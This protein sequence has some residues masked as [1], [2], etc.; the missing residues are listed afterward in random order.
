MTR[1]R[2]NRK[3]TFFWQAVLIIL[4]VTVLA[5]V[6]FFSLRQDKLLAEE[7]A[8]QQAQAIAWPLARE[9]GTRLKIA[10]DDFAQAS[11][12]QEMAVGMIAGTVEPGPQQDARE[13]IGN[14]QAT[15]A[16]W[17]QEHPK[18]Q[19]SQLPQ[20]RCY[21]REGVLFYPRD[22]SEVPEPPDWFV[23]LPSDEAERWNAAETAWGRHDVAAARLALEAIARARGRSDD[24][25]RANAE[26]KLLLIEA[27]APNSPDRFRAFRELALKYPRI[28]TEAG[29]PL[30][31][32]AGHHALRLAPSGT[33]FDEFLDGFVFHVQNAPSIL[34]GKLL[35]EVESRAKAE[36][37]RAQ[38]RVRAIKSVWAAQEQARKLL[39]PVAR[40]KLTR[41]GV[42]ELSSE[43]GRFLAFC[44]PSVSIATNITL[45]ATNVSTTV[46]G[47]IL[48]VPVS[49]VDQAFQRAM[50]AGKVRPPDYAAVHLGFGAQQFDYF[51]ASL[52]KTGVTNHSAQP[53][54]T[55]VD[56]VSPGWAGGYFP[57]TLQLDLVDPELLFARHRQRVGLFGAVIIL[58]A[59]TA[60]VGLLASW[61]S[62]DR[63]QR[64]AEMKTNFVS[65]VSH[66]LRAPIAS[67]RLMAESLDRGKIPDPKK[68]TEYFRLIVQECRRLTSLIENVLDFSRMDQGRKQYE[69]EPTDLVALVRETVCLM[70]PYAAERQV[71]L[72]IA[73][74]A[75]P[76]TT[77][78][79]QPALDSR[80][81]QQ[82]LVNLLDNAIKHSPPG[83]TVL[84]GCEP[85]LNSQPSTVNLFVQD[86]GDGIPL[87]QH[88]KIFEPFYR[89]GSELRRETQGIGI[90]LTIV[91]H[92]V[93]AHSGRVGVQSEVG[94][95][96]RFTIELPV[97][98][99][100]NPN[101]Q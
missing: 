33:G 66:E 79:L 12:R 19:L 18:V 53:L 80:A 14:G 78:N 69:F 2:A 101:F 38:E 97:E 96:S 11:Q 93:K 81:I 84:V 17:Q 26:L 15:V 59:S 71:T 13:E 27:D 91:K 30:S 64:L 56:G 47:N 63:Q 55:V 28:Q 43:S 98:Q 25:V 74:D 61:R 73:P 70:E 34:T 76:I 29:L 16:R 23:S 5:G 50:R 87:A 6:G 51:H 24:P 41:L 86:H 77:N 44:S 72:E 36:D 99:I 83:T 49:V 39:R 3:S 7:E 85:S 42:V 10:I 20:T 37:G 75:P 52:M 90:G 82:A 45:A 46:S 8:R 31:D 40:D 94:K 48:L 88:E 4:P 67:V 35:D 60:L 95:G 58:A 100:P 68:Q 9:C 92:V 54:A 21:F 89:C 1:P 32:V 62:F 57:L 65:S 22:Y